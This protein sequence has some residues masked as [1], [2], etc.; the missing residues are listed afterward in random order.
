MKII[1]LI[2]AAILLLPGCGTTS[3]FNY[4][5]RHFVEDYD[6]IRFKQTTV[7]ADA[8]VSRETDSKVCKRVSAWVG[9]EH[10]IA[11]DAYKVAEVGV[12]CS[13]EMW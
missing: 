13:F 3:E 12:N 10:D 6:V 4:G 1:I 8:K 5:S 2:I 9:G 11:G 7:F